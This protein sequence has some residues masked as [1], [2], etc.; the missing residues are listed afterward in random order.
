[1]CRKI[2]ITSE[3]DEHRL[4][5][6]RLLNSIYETLRT[7]A[8]VPSDGDWNIVMDSVDHF[9]LHYNWLSKYSFS[10]GRLN[11]HLT[12][13]FHMLWHLCYFSKYLNPRSVWCYEFEDLIRQIV[14]SAKNCVAGSSM[15]QVAQ[16]VC[17]NYLLVLNLAL[18]GRLELL[19]A[20][21][22]TD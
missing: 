21:M 12:I 15:A 18:L 20:P 22:P 13:K 7:A 19:A 10:K 5:A 17:Q 8:I 6:L 1:V 3:R 9:L 4:E 14:R 16:K 11:Y 2:G